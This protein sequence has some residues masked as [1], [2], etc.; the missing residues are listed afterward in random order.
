MPSNIQPL[1]E[2]L[3]EIRW[4]LSEERETAQNMIEAA[5]EDMRD[6]PSP[7]IDRL[8]ANLGVARK[9]ADVDHRLCV[10]YLYA[11]EFELKRLLEAE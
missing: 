8:R 5:I 3:R 4:N 11:S 10:S 9:F 2:K 6:T 7:I 1:I